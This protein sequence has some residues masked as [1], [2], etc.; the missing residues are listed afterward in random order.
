MVF[1]KVKYF[2]I[3]I[4]NTLKGHRRKIKLHYNLII[5][6]FIKVTYHRMWLLLLLVTL[7]Y[8]RTELV[9]KLMKYILTLKQI[10]FSVLVRIF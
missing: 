3:K 1:I 4:Y 5:L 6:A 7:N 2:K 9:H 8:I 10:I